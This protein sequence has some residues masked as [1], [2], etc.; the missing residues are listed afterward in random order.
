MF[1]PGDEVT[2]V[3]EGEFRSAFT[4]EPVSGPAF[5]EVYVVSEAFIACGEP[6][7]SLVGVPTPWAGGWRASR[8]RKVQKRNETRNLT[9]WLSQP[10]GYDEE[11]QNPA[12]MAPAKKRERA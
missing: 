8:F 2:L 4:G 6:A 5:G 11:Q 1:A 12:P 7:I 3:S 9:E 10:S